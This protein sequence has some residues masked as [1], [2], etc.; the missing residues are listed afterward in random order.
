MPVR[1]TD[2]NHEKS[3]FDNGCKTN[4]V[5][6][7]L[8]KRVEQLWCI[9]RPRFKTFVQRDDARLVWMIRHT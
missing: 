5:P 8:N 4:L 2:S 3:L 7:K 9:I 6:T 1:L